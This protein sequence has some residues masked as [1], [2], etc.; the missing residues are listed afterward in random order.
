MKVSFPERE[1][2]GRRA[3][4]GRLCHLFLCVLGTSHKPL[5]LGPVCCVLI[6]RGSS[7]GALRCVN[8]RSALRLKVV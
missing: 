6:G 2:D 7:A 1:G 5:L 3:A 8:L 4:G